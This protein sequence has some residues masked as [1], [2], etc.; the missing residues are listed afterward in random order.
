MQEDLQSIH[1]VLAPVIGRETWGVQVGYAGRLTVN[2]GIARTETLRNGRSFTR[3]DWQ[4]WTTWSPWRVETEAEALAASEDPDPVRHAAVERLNGRLLRAI[5]ISPITADTT[6]LFDGGLMLRIFNVYMDPREDHDHWMV[7][8][9]SGDVLTLGPSAQWSYGKGEGHPTPTTDLAIARFEKLCA[10]AWPCQVDTIAL[11]RVQDTS[12]ARLDVHM[13]LRPAGQKDQRRIALSFHGVHYLNLAQD[14][15]GTTLDRLDIDNVA[16][17]QW[18]GITY[19]VHD[20]GQHRLTFYCA[21]FDIV[22]AHD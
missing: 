13:R 3:G 11:Q 21:S 18:D 9:P 22:I 7:F 1:D 5:D 16:D 10:R 4:L 12:P 6:F 2:F 14:D 20:P 15:A 19:E 8:L 17:R